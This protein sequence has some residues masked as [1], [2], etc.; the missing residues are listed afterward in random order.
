MQKRRRAIFEQLGVIVSLPKVH[1]DQT[2]ARVLMMDFEEGHS[3]T[4]VEQIEKSGI[5]MKDLALL[6]SSVFQAQIF[7][8]GFVHCDPRPANVHRK[9]K[10]GKPQLVLLDHGLYKQIDD[11]FRITSAKL[12]KSLLMADIE[13]I[14]ASCTSLGIEEMYPLLAAM[15]ISRPFDEVMQ[16]SKSK[17][18]AAKE[19]I[20][21][22]SDAAM[23]RGYKEII[24]M[25]DKVP[26]QSSCC[27][28]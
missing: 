24:Q 11:D 22:A 26:R 13:G 20:D 7:Q 6:I 23:I 9:E 10:N 18:C 3:A 28:K 16:K 5:K 14:K 2:T 1:W 4:N 19:S 12:W 17:S 27:S 25:L 21:S 15:L 8:S